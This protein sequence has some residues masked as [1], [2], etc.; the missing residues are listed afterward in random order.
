MSVTM[1]LVP[2][3]LA[4]ATVAG[5]AGTAGVLSML[6]GERARGEIDRDRE[7]GDATA[8]PRPVEVRTRMKDPTLLADALRA[9]GATGVE[10]VEGDILAEVDGIA[11]RLSRTPDEVWQ[12]HAER[13]DGS[14]LAEADAVALAER[15]DAAYAAEVQ[16]A[17]AAR[18]RARADAAGFELSSETRDDDDTLTM[19]LTVKDYA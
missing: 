6:G 9:L 7:V 4:A 5:T 13:V 12:I 10:S 2:A 11:L 18:I 1:L 19:V 17:V 16:R 3:A 14:E 15:L 8:A